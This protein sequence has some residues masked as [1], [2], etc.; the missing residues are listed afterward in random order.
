[1]SAEDLPEHWDQIAR[2]GEMATEIVHLK[3][4]IEELESGIRA[5][6]DATVGHEMC[7]ENDQT[8]WALLGEP[9]PNDHTP[10]PWCEFM[11]RC[12]LYRAGREGHGAEA[13]LCAGPGRGVPGE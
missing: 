8:L 9:D 2:L 4:R 1:M 6:R 13:L 7:W 11:Q 12:A 10:P 3:A 5:H